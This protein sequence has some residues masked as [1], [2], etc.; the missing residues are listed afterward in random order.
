MLGGKINKVYGIDYNLYIC[1]GIGGT[2]IKKLGE[3]TLLF[4]TEPE[5]LKTLAEL[6]ADHTV[7]EIKPFV[8]I[9]NREEYEI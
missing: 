5:M 1:R 7:G 9:I 6:K 2:K 8:S 3:H 4:Y